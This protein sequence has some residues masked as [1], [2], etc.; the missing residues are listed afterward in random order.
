MFSRIEGPEEQRLSHEVTTKKAAFL[1]KF[2]C[3]DE[4]DFDEL[5]DSL[6]DAWEFGLPVISVN[7]TLQISS[8]D[9]SSSFFFST[10][11]LTTIGESMRGTVQSNVYF[12][13]TVLIFQEETIIHLGLYSFM[14]AQ[15]YTGGPQLVPRPYLER[16]KRT[17]FLQANL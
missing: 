17:F 13:S 4:E 7:E 11:L 2:D 12:I 3:I 6:R 10:T 15:A 8:W 14:T 9:F 5:I 16:T 1:A